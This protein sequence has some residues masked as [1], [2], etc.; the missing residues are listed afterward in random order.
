MVGSQG[1]SVPHHLAEQIRERGRLVRTSHAWISTDHQICRSVLRDNRFGAMTEHNTEVPRILQWVI[2]ATDT[3]ALNPSGPPTMVRV[4]PP[5]HT[6]FRRSIA[7]AFTP[8]ALS[9]LRDQI[10][11]ITDELLGTIDRTP[12]IEQIQDFSTLLP[13]AI[14]AELLGLPADTWVP[15]RDWAHS[16]NALFGVGM[17]WNDFRTATDSLRAAERFYLQHID[18][19]RRDPAP[20]LLGRMTLASDLSDHEIAATAMLL[21][22]G[23]IGT[24]GGLIANGVKHLLEHP[25]QLDSLRTTPELW[26]NAVEEILRFDPFA[27]ILGRVANCDVE[28]GDTRI[29]AGQTVV[30]MLCSANRDPAVFTNPTEFDIL[31]P[32]A[33]AHLSFGSGIHVCIGQAL[34]RMQGIHALQTIFER[35]PDLGAGNSR[36]LRSAAAS[37]NRSRPLG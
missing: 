25:D 28:F 34:A 19:L 36:G 16:S 11:R 13:A 22:D 24:T 15:L 8:Q 10:T 33:K 17:S 30:V 20:G 37:T 31:R 27:P 12:S 4:D 23:S 2:R 29:L 5:D 21:A 35:F 3:E 6:R 9:T 7:P 14:A 18:G 32:N 26:P 1:H